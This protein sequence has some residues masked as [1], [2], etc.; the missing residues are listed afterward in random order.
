MPAPA[1]QSTPRKREP[2]IEALVREIVRQPFD[3]ARFV[4]STAMRAYQRVNPPQTYTP[5]TSQGGDP[6]FHA[7]HWILREIN[8]ANREADKRALGVVRGLRTRQPRKKNP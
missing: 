1:R 4:P 2:M 3:V 8:D 5:S 6:V 7:L